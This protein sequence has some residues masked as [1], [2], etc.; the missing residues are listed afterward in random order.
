[1]S[2]P[3]CAP[4]QLRRRRHHGH[5]DRV[6]AL[7]AAKDQHPVGASGRSN[8]RPV[9]RLRRTRPTGLPATNPFPE[10]TTASG[11]RSPP[12]RAPS[13]R[14]ADWSSPARR[15]AP[16]PSSGCG[17]A[18][19]RAPPARS[20]S[21]RRRSRR[22]GRRRETMPPRVD[23]AERQRAARR[24]ARATID[25]PFSP[26][27]RITSSSNPS[28]GTTRASRPRA[29]PQTSPARPA[30]R[31]R[32]SRATAI[33]GYRCPPV[34]PPAITTDSAVDARVASRTRLHRF[35][36]QSP[37]S[38]RSTSLP[39]ATP[40]ARCS[41]GCPSRSGSSAATIRRC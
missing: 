39:P 27:L 31:R 30:A 14:A 6:R 12:P 21:R 35:S 13:A 34:P 29:V 17:A 23:E 38:P 22:R 37:A 8:V 10:R 5:V 25:L 19:R 2:R 24:A 32:I 33:P 1:M 9:R 16:A 40:A 26:A 41:A 36:A 18:P 4:H 3:A 28:R 20:C 15:S 7:G 11:R